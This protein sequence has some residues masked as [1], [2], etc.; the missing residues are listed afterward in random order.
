MK[1]FLIFIIAGLYATMTI[2]PA[3][4]AGSLFP[5]PPKGWKQTDTTIIYSPDELYAYINGGA[6]LFLSYGMKEVASQ[7][8]S[9]GDMEVR[10]EIFDMVT[11]ADAFGVF[12]HTRTRNEKKYGQGSQLFPGTLIFWKDRFYV[13]VTANDINE[14]LDR[15]I[16]YYGR[17]VDQAISG[18]ANLPGILDILPAENLDPAGILYFH[19]Y[20]WQNAY[21][22]IANENLLNIEAGTPAVL[23]KYNSGDRQ[24]FLLIIRYPDEVASSKAAAN[25]GQQFFEGETTPVMIEDNSWWNMQ[26]VGNY[27]LLVMNA[28]SSEESVKLVARAEQNI[29]KNQSSE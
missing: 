26:V 19:H 14:T 24:I 25:F 5:P 28:H 29:K 11:G 21:H 27:L 20:I 13:S 6:E 18:K 22:Y 3:Q 17:S 4:T 8:I 10:V 7:R 1:A 15:V 9:R 23:A 2:T 16:E 12:S